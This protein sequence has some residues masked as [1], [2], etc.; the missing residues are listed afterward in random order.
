ML[1]VQASLAA[2]FYRLG[3][4]WTK[5]GVVVDA[6]EFVEEQ[7]EVL[8]TEVNLN[9]REAT[10]EEIAKRDSGGDAVLTASP[11]SMA[12][13][14]DTLIEAIPAL[15]DAEF[16]KDGKPR[17]KALRKAVEIDAALVTQDASEA[18]MEK[19]VAGG[20]KPPVTEE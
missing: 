11:M 15:L 1:F 14:V 3:R 13:V 7:W 16:T 18:A 4:K 10:K 19:L 5:E 8:Q 20:F 6:R 9:V 2:H 12:E 17:M